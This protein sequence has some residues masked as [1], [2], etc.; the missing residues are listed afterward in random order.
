VSN[1]AI[2]GNIISN[3]N[4]YKG[5]YGILLNVG[6]SSAHAADISSVSD[7]SITGNDISGLTGGWEHAVGLETDTPNAQVTG[8]TIHA[9]TA[10]SDVEAVHFEKNPSASTVDLSGTTFN[11]NSL[12]N[13]ASAITVD[14]SAI[15]V[16]SSSELNTYL[17]V[18]EGTT[19]MYTG[20]N[21]FST[22]PAAVSAAPASGTVNVNAGTY[23]GVALTGSYNSNITIQGASATTINGLDLSGSVFDGLTFKDFTFTGDSTGYGD[24]S[25]TIASD[26][27]YGNLAFEDDT[28]DGQSAA[29]RGAIFLNRGFDGFTL[30]GDTFKGYDG[31]SYGTVYSVVFAEAQSATWGDNFTATENSLTDST[32]KNFL[33]TYRW[34]DV[35]LNHNTVNADGGRPLCGPILSAAHSNPSEP[36]T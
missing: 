5:A 4:S 34:K 11:G 18:L 10:G 27:T 6:A 15:V 17:E 7:A 14:S 22:I 31:S 35:D 19:Y 24:F 28:F 2:T 13:S 33:E 29:G 9:L 8:N 23:S 16:P 20:L 1:P 12:S 30:R 32:A 26:G 3:V 25:V 36:S 21:V